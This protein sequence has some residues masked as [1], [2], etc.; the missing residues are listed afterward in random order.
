VPVADALV[1]IPRADRILIGQRTGFAYYRDHRLDRKILIGVHA[2]NV[3][4]NNYLD[5]PF[6]QL[7]ENFIEGEA[8][9][10]AILHADPSVKGRIG[11]LGHYTGT[12]GRY[13]IDPYMIYRQ[14][15]ELVRIHA[16]AGTRLKRDDYYRCFH[17]PSR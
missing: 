13:L 8:L 16:C 10:D 7:P 5:G 17:S 11:R 9:R 15:G 12:D 3:Q 14:P 6:D 1:P 2:S 4:A